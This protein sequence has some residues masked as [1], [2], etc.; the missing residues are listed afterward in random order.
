MTHKGPM[1]AALIAVSTALG[2]CSSETTSE[3]TE[4]S[5]QSAAAISTE[6]LEGACDQYLETYNRVAKQTVDHFYKLYRAAGQSEDRIE[7]ARD[8]W[9]FVG[10]TIEKAMLNDEW[11]SLTA[12]H[13]NLQDHLRSIAV[14]SSENEYDFPEDAEAAVRM[15]EE[16]E[17]AYVRCKFLRDIEQKAG[18]AA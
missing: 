17:S 12:W 9:R 6:G 14:L 1:M 11:A 8:H 10:G 3:T 2:A 16:L 13:R 7:S 4:A 18:E 15:S 5:N